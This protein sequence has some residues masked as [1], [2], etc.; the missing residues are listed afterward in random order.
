MFGLS[1]NHKT[2]ALAVIAT[3]FL[4]GVV[5]TG[6]QRL[7]IAP[8][9][10]GREQYDTALV[11]WNSLNVGEYEET[12][13]NWTGCRYR[14]IVSIDRSTGTPVETIV[15]SQD[16]QV[17]STDGCSHD[18]A[19]LLDTVSTLF[20]LVDYVLTYPSDAA[21]NRYHGFRQW[22]SAEFDPEMGYPRYY[23]AF[24]GLITLETRIEALKVL[25]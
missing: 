9:N 5:A 15:D 25:K 20:E 17:P 12:V 1:A 13:R 3:L 6:S 14:L 24:G 23:G 22:Y 18:G 10:V 4:S 7:H 2:V 11:K 21:I 19:G 8:I 16:L